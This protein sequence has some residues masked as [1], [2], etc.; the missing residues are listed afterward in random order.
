M[1]LSW[2]FLGWDQ[3]PM[4]IS[5]RVHAAGPIAFVVLIAQLIYMATH[6]WKYVRRH[7]C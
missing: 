3:L 2:H 6:M 1:I 5:L 4:S 7:M